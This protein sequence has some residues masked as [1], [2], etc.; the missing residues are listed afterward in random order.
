[1]TPTVTP[2]PAFTTDVLTYHNDNART[3]QNLNETI[4]SPDTV[5]SSG[6]G[7]LFELPVDGKVD[8]QPLIKTQVNIP[9][10]GV[11]NVLYVVTEHDSVYAFDAGNGSLL[12]PV[13]VSLLASGETPS[14]PLGCT[15][16]TPE[17][18]ITSTPVI[19]TNLGPHGTMFVV[20]MSK[21][22]LGNYFQRIHALDITTGAEEFG[23]PVTIA[24]T[25]PGGGAGNVNGVLTFAAKMFEDRAGLVE[26]NG[27]VYTTWASHCDHGPYTGWIIGYGLNAQNTLVRTTVLNI[28]PNGS[29]GAIWQAGTGPAAD[30]QGNIYALDG[31]GTFDT[32]LTASGFPING[33]F[34][35]GFLKLSTAGGLG[36]ADYFATFDTVNQSALDRD[37][38]SGGA[39]V[40][41]DMTDAL[42]ATRHLAVGAGKDGNIYL[43]DRDNMGKFNP[44]DNSN[45]YQ[46]VV[47]AFPGEY[48]MPAYFNSR[49][50]YGGRNA[51]L[52]VFVFANAL[53]ASSP[54]SSTSAS[55]AYPGTT[56]S[57]S[58]YGTK[59]AIV[60]A[61]RNA[62]THGVLHA[63][64]AYN[65]GVE[66]YNSDQAANSRDS[67]QDNKF[68]TP[69]IANGMVY[70]G[71]PNSV[72][73]FG[74]LNQGFRR[75]GFGR[76]QARMR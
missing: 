71:T 66:Y 9:E 13:A 39:L 43:A 59:N 18:G 75:Q 19:D 32:T 38:G 29:D 56:P 45:L 60:W 20:A 24:A 65:L 41:P 10:Q 51:P 26:V 73:V 7:K 63:Y 2:T 1:M 42:G 17:I 23:G 40:L 34:G 76:K 27:K 21:D 28:T 16:V 33:D 67:F 62:T 4:L 64:N 35:N 46:E 58:G 74:L 14:D 37:L 22:A 48:G 11:R 47:G 15:Q 68:I 49:L 44:T 36:V 53:L 52:K 3:G 31:N 57:I 25:Y 55:F 50:Y 69:T 61:V 30:N 6:F 72:A 54:S 70:V 8:A 5:N 12:W